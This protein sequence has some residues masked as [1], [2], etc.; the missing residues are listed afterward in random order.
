[1]R[2]ISAF[3]DSISCTMSSP[4]ELTGEVIGFSWAQWDL[5]QEKGITISCEVSL[6]LTPEGHREDGR[7]H[8]CGVKLQHNAVKVGLIGDG[9]RKV[10]ES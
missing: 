4:L 8:K 6:T 7:V 3:P 1:M 9:M 2:Y 5:E 10:I